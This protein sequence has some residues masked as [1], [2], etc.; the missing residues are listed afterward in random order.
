MIQLDILELL[1]IYN[2][3]INT[4]LEDLKSK[5]L[6]DLC[7]NEN[8]NN[9]LYPHI[10]NKPYVP[11]NCFNGEIIITSSFN[12]NNSDN[13]YSR[14]KEYLFGD[15]ECTEENTN[16]TCYYFATK[17]VKFDGSKYSFE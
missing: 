10:R 15:K 1:K 5:Y 2:G 4:S 3:T 6:R 17:S 16:L 9:C 13:R 8:K 7:I 14:Y 12:N 11:N